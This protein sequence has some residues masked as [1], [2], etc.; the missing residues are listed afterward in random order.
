ME[1]NVLA[2]GSYS[3]SIGCFVPPHLRIHLAE[4]CLTFEVLE[5]GATEQQWQASRKAMIVPPTRWSRRQA[6]AVTDL[7]LAR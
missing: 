7:R 3:I 4:E 5:T 6:P 2:P 1:S